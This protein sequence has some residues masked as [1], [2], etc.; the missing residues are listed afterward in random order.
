MKNNDI[1]KEKLIKEFFRKFGDFFDYGDVNDFISEAL[2]ERDREWKKIVEEIVHEFSMA[3]DIYEIK[4]RTEHE[5]LSGD[6]AENRIMEGLRKL[7][8]EKF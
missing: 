1:L 7:L 6:E 5:N 3:F 4:D 8:N 2:E